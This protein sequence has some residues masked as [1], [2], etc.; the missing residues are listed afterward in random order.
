MFIIQ[1]LL[2]EYF[3]QLDDNQVQK[4]EMDRACSK[5]G[6][7]DNGHGILVGKSEGKR[8]LGR[9]RCM[10]E[11]NTKVDLGVIRW[12][13]VDWI[14]LDQERDQWRAPVNTVMNL[15]VP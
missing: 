15:Q 9:A 10:C 7:E 13:S 2:Y 5:Q 11:D 1:R 12:D 8:P 14:D 3:K 4:D 6:G